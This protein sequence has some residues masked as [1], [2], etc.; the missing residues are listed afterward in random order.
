MDDRF[1]GPEITDEE[2][3]TFIDF[4]RGDDTPYLDDDAD[5]DPDVSD[6]IE[7]WA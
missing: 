6:V 2:I 7:G 3:D 5:I 4:T 1:F